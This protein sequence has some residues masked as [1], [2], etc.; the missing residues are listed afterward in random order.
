MAFSLLEESKQIGQSTNRS[1]H[2]CLIVSD[3][4]DQPFQGNEDQLKIC[5]DNLTCYRQQCMLKS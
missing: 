5:A 1:Q 2:S 4:S 3:L